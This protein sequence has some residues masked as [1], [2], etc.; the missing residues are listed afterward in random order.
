MAYS[1]IYVRL[2]S[3]RRQ[4]VAA[5]QALWRY[6]LARL[7]LLLLF[8]TNL[9]A[10]VGAWLV[11]RSLTGEFLVLHYNVDFGIDRLGSPFQIYAYPGFSLAVW[12]VNLLTA[13]LLYRHRNFRLFTHLLLLAA[14]LFS[15]FLDVSLFFI[16]LINFR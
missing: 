1:G 7:Y 14:L 2:Y 10:A 9:L 13:L 6:R 15:A 3:F 5:W 11:A 16:Y 8:I 4:A 12:L